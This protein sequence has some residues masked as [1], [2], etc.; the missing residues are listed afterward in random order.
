MR[1]LLSPRATASTA[2]TGPA[3]STS[4]SLAASAANSIRF[5]TSNTALT[6][7][8]R[9]KIT[10]NGSGTWTLDSNGYLVAASVAS[11]YNTWAAAKGLTGLP[12]S[13]T[14]PAKDADPDNDGRN[15][16]G[17]FA[18]NGDPLSGSDN[19]KVFALTEDSDFV[20]DPSNAKELIL[21]VAVRSGT[22][23]FTGSPLSAIHV[24][25]GIT[26]SI[27]GSLDLA[28]FPTAVNV[29]PTPLTIDLPA[30][31]EGYEYR[32]FSLDGSNGLTGKGFLRAKV[33]SP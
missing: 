11:A 28:G 14:D 6:A 12:G 16:L 21:T 31:G 29:V 9:S 17:E 22:P 19:G 25:D 23:V 2:A 13:S 5:G 10:V 18:F 32:S 15:N 8:Q 1:L 20:G 30:A 7:G 3:P 4:A 24:S 33:T 26:Y 27:E